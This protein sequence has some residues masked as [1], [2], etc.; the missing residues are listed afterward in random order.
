MLSVS[1]YTDEPRI[2]LRLLMRLKKKLQPTKKGFTIHPDDV[3]PFIR[4]L[5]VIR[6]Y[7]KEKE[8]TTD[9]KKK[10]KFI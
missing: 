5:E 2:D 8:T 7:M 3:E 4:A 1:E 6:E 10:R 9:N